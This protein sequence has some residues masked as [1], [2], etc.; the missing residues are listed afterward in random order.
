MA[1]ANRFPQPDLAQAKQAHR[2]SSGKVLVGSDPPARPNSSITNAP[3]GRSAGTF[4]RYRRYP[5]LDL[6]LQVQR[7]P[8]SGWTCW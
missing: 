4:G 8:R 1:R 2:A 5:P 6:P 7:M 3:V